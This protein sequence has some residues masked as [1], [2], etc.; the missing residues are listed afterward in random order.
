MEINATG[1]TNSHKE[2][3][4]K[5]CVCLRP[6]G[7]GQVQYQLSTLTNFPF[8]PDTSIQQT[9]TILPHHKTPLNYLTVKSTLL[10]YPK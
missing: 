4:L 6:Y 2:Q 5:M 8:L 1:S 7:V 3:V 10:L 9:N